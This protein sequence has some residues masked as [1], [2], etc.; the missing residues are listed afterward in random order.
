MILLLLVSSIAQ[1]Q[2]PTGFTRVNQ[3]YNW[4][5]GK[6]DNTF[7]IVPQDTLTVPL[8]VGEI[9]LR[10][11]GGDSTLYTGLSTTAA[12]KW[13]ATGGDGK[14]FGIEDSTA[15][16]DRKFKLN[17]NVLFFESNELGDGTI[18]I[19]QKNPVYKFATGEAARPKLAVTHYRYLQDTGLLKDDSYSFLIDQQDTVKNNLSLWFFKSAALTRQYFWPDSLLTINVNDDYQHNTFAATYGGGFKSKTGVDSSKVVIPATSFRGAVNVVMNKFLFN[20][21]TKFDVSGY[22]ANNQYMFETTSP[23]SLQKYADISIGSIARKAGNTF[24]IDDK[25]GLYINPI[26][27]DYITRAWGVYQEGASDKNYWGGRSIFGTDTVDD[28]STPLQVN[29]TAKVKD[30]LLVNPSQ[31]G[32]GVHAS[33]WLQYQ[34][35]AANSGTSAGVSVIS[36]NNAVGTKG[37]FIGQRARGTLD[38]LQDVQ[39]GDE[40][41]GFIGGGI[42]NGSRETPAE[43]AMVVDGA[44][45][46]GT[47]PTSIV[48]KTGTNGS[49]RTARLK[50][51]SNGYI[52]VPGLASGGTA[53]TTS[54]TTK[55]VI[56]DANGLL[57]FADIPTGGGS[58]TVNTGTSG[59]LAY[60]ASTGTSVSEN[61]SLFWDATN[62]RLGVRTSSPGGRLTID[63]GNTTN[64]RSLSITNVGSGTTGIAIGNLVIGDRSGS[65]YTAMDIANGRL[66]YQVRG[67]SLG[68]NPAHL[69]STDAGASGAATAVLQSKGGAAGAKLFSGVQ[70]DNTEVFSVSYTGSV[71]VGGSPGTAKLHLPAGTAT[72]NTAPLKFTSGTNLTTPE[73]GAVEF[74]GTHLYFTVGSTRYQA[75]LTLKTSAVIDFPSLADNNSNIQNVTVTGAAIGDQVLVTKMGAWSNGEVYVAFV[76]AADTVSI[77]LQNVSGGTFDIGSDTYN[78]TVFK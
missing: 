62:E 25:Y 60:Y 70:S 74:D 19:G 71:A 59:R 29:G 15:V 10:T 44:V 75:S 66:M 53:P 3:K 35:T 8:F 64:L 52:T 1:A 68:A 14:H 41:V 18:E 37:V 27:D 46:A 28:G 17:G 78:V 51:S 23:G 33:P 77:R 43:M 4:L 7:G 69:F 34:L 67:S 58:G 31:I 57:S 55:M 45:S 30:Q 2:V 50:V 39:N 5:G 49:N 20:G 24:R 12:K 47:I 54:G 21:G 26:K 22:L 72:A 48:L 6:F 16:A 13:Y 42:A 56:T 76:S 36:A 73:N 32:I 63:Q 65:A 61:T 11:T 38:A 40:L 9:R